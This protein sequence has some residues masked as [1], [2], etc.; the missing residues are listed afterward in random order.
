[1]Q[2]FEQSSVFKPRDLSGEDINPRKVPVRTPIEECH[3]LF[4]N[5]T[6]NPDM[7]IHHFYL[8]DNSQ[9]M[10]SEVNP[11]AENPQSWFEF[12]KAEIAFLMRKDKFT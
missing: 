3:T 4:I 11:D 8:F 7:R 12:Y 2:K 6:V 10:K 5:P 1:M 9:G